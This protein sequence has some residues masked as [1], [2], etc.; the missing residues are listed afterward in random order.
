[1]FELKLNNKTIQLKWG[2]WAM[3][4]L[5]IAKEISIEEYFSLL[6]RSQLDLDLIVKMI[7]FGYKSACISNKEAIEYTE[8]DVC[9]W[10]DEVGSIFSTEGQVISY[11]KY[12]ITNTVNSVQS[13]AKDEKKKSKVVKLG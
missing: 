3:K 7:F 13:K 2:T 12:I 6:G 5:C 9:D 11:F 8:I 10:I 1:M 4:E